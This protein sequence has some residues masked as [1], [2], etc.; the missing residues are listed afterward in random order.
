MQRNKDGRLEV[1]FAGTNG[2]VHH[3]WQDASREG[4]WSLAYSLGGK[5]MQG[6]PAVQ[7]NEDG[8]LEVFVWD[9]ANQLCHAW[10][11][12]GGGWSPWRVI[13]F[14]DPTGAITAAGTPA[15]GRNNDKRIE[16][17]VRGSDGKLWHA[18]QPRVN[19]MAASEVSQIV[20]YPMEGQ[21]QIAGHPAIKNG[22]GKLEV[23]WVDA[24]GSLA[25]VFQT[26]PDNGW[27]AG[28]SVRLGGS[29][30]N[31]PTIGRAAD[32]HLEVFARGLDNCIYYSAQTAPG[33]NNWTPV[34]SLGGNYPSAPAVEVNK[35]GRLDLFLISGGGELW[36]LKQFPSDF[37]GVTNGHFSLN[38]R[39]FRHVGVNT[40]ELVYHTGPQTTNDLNRLRQAGVRQVR[41]FLANDTHNTTEAGDRLR[42]LINQAY[43][44]GIRLT[45]AIANMYDYGNGAD[46]AN[47]GINCVM[48]DRG[49]YTEKRPAQGCRVLNHQW[50]VDNTN[51]P[52]ARY[53]QFVIAVVTR[54]KDHP[55]IFAWEVGNEISDPLVNDDKGETLL[56]F[57]A[58]AAATIK[59]IDRYHLV[60]PG[61]ISTR[62][63]GLTDQAKRERLY[64][65]FDY[66]TEHMYYD[67][68][69]D[70]S[71]GYPPS[72][73]DLAQQLNKP[74]V[75]EEFGVHKSFG[76]FFTQVEDFFKALYGLPEMWNNPNAPKFAD[77]I[78]IWGVEYPTPFPPGD[79]GY[80]GSGDDRYGPR[81]Q[82]SVERY[83][84]LWQNW[85]HLL[86]GGND[87]LP[88]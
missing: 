26:R 73:R 61:I 38:G 21:V 55:G 23:L 86:D 33:S 85:A 28:G 60:A 34:T 62:Q 30:Q 69:P 41:V 19:S 63:V 2:E 3:I 4:G 17:F 53:L 36:Q 6:L 80:N 45:V 14:N 71:T 24:D 46:M 56:K 51:D 12:P 22:A 20:L 59:S 78:M 74:L 47:S 52:N 7:V 31:R 72:D 16:V 15:A 9:T 79:D 83:D 58:K 84:Q 13:R 48:G 68:P 8:R 81:S 64:R 50:L 43:P 1:F 42:D 27:N 29:V 66:V 11:M 10:Q 87:V 39:K 37:V 65:D 70:G 44:L 82:N 49:Y 40:H 75:I 77:S 25:H 5:Q 67:P 18:W 88:R 35:D 32:G 57:Y 54:F 76:N